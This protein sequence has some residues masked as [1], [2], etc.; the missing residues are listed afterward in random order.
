MSENGSPPGPD[1]LPGVLKTVN[2]F[3]A[4]N[5]ACYRRAAG[6]TQEQLGKEIGRSKRNVSADERSWD[7]DRTREFS[8][9]EIACYAAAL[10]VPVSAMFLPPD[11]DGVGARYLWHPYEDSPDTFTMADLTALALP[12]SASTSRAM[13][14]YRRRVVAAMRQYMPPGWSDEA[15]RWLDPM[16]EAELRDEEIE[17][18]RADREAAL[19]I[20]AKIGRVIAGYEQERGTE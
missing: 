13:D 15:D 4:W 7:G 11:D 12:V 18:L 17:D 10:E 20:A 1:D 9:S 8:A 14:A 2:Q 5:I 3:V 19:R 16:T 6:L